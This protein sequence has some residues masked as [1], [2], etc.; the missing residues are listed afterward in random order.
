MNK[1]ELKGKIEEQEKE[2]I[3]LFNIFQYRLHEETMQPIIKQWREGSVKLKVLID[4]LY[5]L[6]IKEH[7]ERILNEENKK[8]TKTFVNGYG[9]ATNKYITSSTY[10]RAEK[11]RQKEILSFIGGWL[12][13]KKP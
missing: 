1:E 10:E 4:E 12:K 6:E 2:N 13:Y 5:E 3:G 7:N 8:E 9:E 11:R